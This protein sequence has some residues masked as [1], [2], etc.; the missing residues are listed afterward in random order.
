MNIR[1]S[2]ILFLDVDGVINP[3]KGAHEEP[4][5]QLHRVIGESGCSIVLS[6][7][8]RLMG[9]RTAE[10]QIRRKFGY[11]GP[12]F[13]G[14]TPDLKGAPR[15]TEISAWIASQEFGPMPPWAVVDDYDDMPYV[16]HRFVRTQPRIGLDEVGADRLIE[17]LKAW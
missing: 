12:G 10:D 2:S 13:F 15:G 11:Q 1:P 9:I 3:H 14:A 5:R 17:L 8:W 7:M 4:V 16:R 6:S